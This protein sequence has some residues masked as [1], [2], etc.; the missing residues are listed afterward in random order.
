MAPPAPAPVECAK[1]PTDSVVAALDLIDGGVCRAESSAATTPEWMRGGRRCRC[2]CG[3]P[4]KSDADCG[5]GIGS[6]APASPAAE[7]P[8]HLLMLV[9]ALERQAAV[10]PGGP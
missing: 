4:C 8:L 10:A 1:A 9:E 2:S 6:A 5:G 7:G 3:Y